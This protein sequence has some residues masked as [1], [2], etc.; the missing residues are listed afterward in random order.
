MERRPMVC[1]GVSRSEAERHGME[2][3]RAVVECRVHSG[4]WLDAMRTGLQFD[5]LNPEGVV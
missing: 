5:V 4:K 3:H 2:H 1:N